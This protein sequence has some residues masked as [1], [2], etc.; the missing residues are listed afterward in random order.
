MPGDGKPYDLPKAT[1]L[2]AIERLKILRLD[3]SAHSGGLPTHLPPR[4]VSFYEQALVELLW[5]KENFESK[6]GEGL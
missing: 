5:Y 3:N 4:N 6:R 2:A 1:L